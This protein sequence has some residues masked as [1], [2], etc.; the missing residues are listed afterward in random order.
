MSEEYE[1]DLKKLGEIIKKSPSEMII[2]LLVLI[3]IILYILFRR[4]LAACNDFY[5]NITETCLIWR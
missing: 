2:V 3:I 4:D 1:L 5:K